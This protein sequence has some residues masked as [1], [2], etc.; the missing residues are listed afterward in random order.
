MKSFLSESRRSITMT[1]ST[2]NVSVMFDVT[3]ADVSFE[4][5]AQALRFGLAALLG[6]ASYVFVDYSL[7]AEEDPIIF[8]YPPIG[9]CSPEWDPPRLS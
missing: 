6:G 3:G 4:T 5:K 1:N 7:A 9:D 2:F 8:E